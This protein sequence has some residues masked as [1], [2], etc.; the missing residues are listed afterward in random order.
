VFI[1]V[2]IVCVAVVSAL[3]NIIV[4]ELLNVKLNPWATAEVY[5]VSLLLLG[6][7]AHKFLSKSKKPTSANQGEE[8]SKTEHKYTKLTSKSMSISAW[9]GGA[10]LMAITIAH[11]ATSG[12]IF[13]PSSLNANSL[14]QILSITTLITIPALT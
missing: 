1:T 12:L 13:V 6:F 10:I 14:I 8:L 3:P 9:A 2:W 11:I 5:S 4:S 7:I